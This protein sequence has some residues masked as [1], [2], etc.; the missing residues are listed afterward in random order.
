[1]ARFHSLVSKKVCQLAEAKQNDEGY[2]CGSE[3]S[4]GILEE[5]GEFGPRVEWFVEPA[6]INDGPELPL[7]VDS[8]LAAAANKSIL[9]DR[10]R[11]CISQVDAPA[12]FPPNM[13]MAVALAPSSIDMR[14]CRSE[15]S[16]PTCFS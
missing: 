6:Y 3:S 7:T 10:P 5:F 16:E 15:T 4:Q 8:A 14:S 9:E 11:P 13:L 12:A 1:M 2:E